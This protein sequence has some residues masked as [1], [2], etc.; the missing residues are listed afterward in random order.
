MQQQR[1]N[2]YQKLEA[3][4]AQGI[5]L[6]PNM[7]I[8]STAPIPTPSSPGEDT[9]STASAVSLSPPPPVSSSVLASPTPSGSGSGV[10]LGRRRTS[11]KNNP[12]LFIF[13]EE[14][15]GLNCCSFISVVTVAGSIATGTGSLSG[16]GGLIKRDSSSNLPLP[17]N[18]ISAKNEQKAAVTNLPIRQQLPM[19][20]AKL[21]SAGGGSSGSSGPAGTTP[22]G[23]AGVSSPSNSSL[24]QQMLPLRLSESLENKRSPKSGGMSVSV[25]EGFRVTPESFKPKLSSS[26][27]SPPTS[28]KNEDFVAGHSRTGSSPASIQ[29]LSPGQ[30]SAQ[31]NL[32]PP[33]K[34]PEKPA[35]LLFQSRH[36]PQHLHQSATASASL[37]AAQQQQQQPKVHDPETNQEIV[38]L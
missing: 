35:T 10:D 32:P 19:K 37:S 38:F 29:M 17:M 25:G 8:V 20:L 26:S 30:R 34:V 18:L 13:S 28:S 2:L 3:L 12:I 7:T 24:V 6:S 4:R 23:T 21:A 33:P 16:S 15:F 1:E 11:N 14:D 27:F 22:G 5:L 9:E 31:P 36:S